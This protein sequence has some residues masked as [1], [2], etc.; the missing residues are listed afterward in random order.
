MSA[1]N[2]NPSDDSANNTDATQKPSAPPAAA[3]AQ[4]KNKHYEDYNW[5]R[6]LG[7]G[8]F[9]AVM[10]ATDK[11]NGRE[12]A[13]K[14]LE[15]AQIIR[16][17]KQK[18]V[19]TERDIL[20]KLDHPNVIKLY[21]TFRSETSLHYVLELCPNGE[22]LK[23]MQKHKTFCEPVIQFYGAE[24]IN[25]LEH[26]HSRGII[27]RDLKPENLLLSKT[28]H[29]KL[30]DFGTAKDLSKPPEEKA[31][32]PTQEVQRT[33]SFVGTAEYVSPEILNAQLDL[34]G[35]TVDLWGLG[36]ILYQMATGRFPFHGKT[37]MLTF[38]R[39]SGRDLKFPTNFPPVLMD[40]IDKLLVV[41]PTE[42]L[43]YR[44]YDELK[45]HP[46]FAGL[47]FQGLWEKDP[48]E[49]TP[50]PVA[51]IF[52]DPPSA[53]PSATV[54]PASAAAATTTTTSGTTTSSASTT[55]STAATS[56]AES[57]DSA[58][59]ARFLKPGEAVIV[60][61]TV[62][63]H[64]GITSQKRELLLTNTPRMLYIHPQELSLKGEVPLNSSIH[65]G[66]SKPPAKFFV[67]SG[68]RTYKFEDTTKNA[69]KWLDGLDSV[70]SKLH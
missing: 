28:M 66:M 50:L 18:Y 31:A 7:I 4:P 56:H 36:C 48:P 17:N 39:I 38:Q 44:G 19:I 41:N 14:V 53:P 32:N 62:I 13:I 46:F 43:G 22:L 26:L 11:E 30:I 29:L 2:N 55:A 24:I 61:G 70:Q 52:D 5:G 33:N 68:K 25:A 67:Q 60:S 20:C 40:L 42:R 10:L 27:H 3:A 51:L 9:G 21:G 47:S 54:P 65:Y 6:Q 64:K 16:L 49:V 15:K 45:S 69:Q 37:D 12:V 58:H 63:K 35:P 59:W 23:L 57:A 1:T 34:I 8:S